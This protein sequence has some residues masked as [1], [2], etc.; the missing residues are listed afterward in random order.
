LIGQAKDVERL[1]FCSGKVYY[2]LIGYVESHQIQNTALVRVE[3]LYPLDLEGLSTTI[4]DLSHAKKW[5]WCQEEPQNM[6]SWTY[7]EPLLRRLAV[8][9]IEYAGR[10]AAA[11][12]AV[13]SKA[14]HDQ[15]QKELVQ[16]AFT[17]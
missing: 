2:D 1:I 5:V 4:G 14:W 9:E 7:I 12:T 6:G 8:H 3:Q 13:G 11:S 10:P 17:V 16:D 15:Q